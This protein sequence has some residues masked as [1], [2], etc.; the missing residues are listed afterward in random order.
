MINLQN[1]TITPPINAIEIDKAIEELRVLLDTNL[2]W[3]SHSYG[4]AYR[5]GEKMQGKLIYPEIYIG[6][7]NFDYFRMIPDNDKKAI[8][9]FTVGKE[10]VENWSNSF[11][12]LKYDVGLIL[13]VNLKA[14]NEPLLNTE[15]FVQN[16]IKDV[17]T[18]LKVQGTGLSFGLK[19][20]SV[21]REFNEIYKEFRLEE[22][23]EYL[24]APYGAF[25]FDLELIINEEC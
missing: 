2:S 21:G 6:G 15:Y 19:A 4:R 8:S 13:W 22:K 14:I 20:K 3:L 24:R 9:F 1:P 25:R 16:L 7:Q 23:E 18:V 12:K 10:K 17:R 5:H 11:N